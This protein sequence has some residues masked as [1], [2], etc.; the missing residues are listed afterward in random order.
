MDSRVSERNYDDS[1]SFEILNQICESCWF[2][3]RRFLKIW[4]P[5]FRNYRNLDFGLT[6]DNI[7]GSNARTDILRVSLDS[8]NNFRTR[9]GLGWYFKGPKLVLSFSDVMLVSCGFYKFGSRK[10][11]VHVSTVSLDLESR[12]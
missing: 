4:D 2:Q 3:I 1:I 12:V 10:L 5:K 7:Q 9:W 11:S 6:F 8:E